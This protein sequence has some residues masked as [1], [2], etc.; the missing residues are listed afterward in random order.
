MYIIFIYY[1]Y[2]IFIYYIYILYLYIIFIYYIYIFYLFIICI[3]YL[4][5]IFIYYIYIL[6]LYIIFIYYIYILYLYIIFIYYFYIL[7]LY[8]IFI[9]YI[10][11]LYLYII[12]I[13]HIYIWSKFKLVQQDTVDKGNPA[14]VGTTVTMKHCKSWDYHGLNHL[15]TGAGFLS[16]HSMSYI[17]LWRSDVPW[18]F[19]KIGVPLFIIHS[20]IWV[21]YSQTKTI[22]RTWGYPHDYGTPMFSSSYTPASPGYSTRLRP[23]ELQ[24]CAV[25]H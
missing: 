5:I 9:Y 22:Q 16:I 8:I 15:P 1:M 6:Y 13:Y 17:P 14:A 25:R 7:Y 18:G 23:V 3:L 10:Y 12:F 20:T 4:Y 19:P 11:I 21:G 2:I 24:R